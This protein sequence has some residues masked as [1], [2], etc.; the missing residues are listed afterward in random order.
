MYISSY[1]IFLL[2]VIFF[3]MIRR[4]PRST[5]TDTLFPYTTLFRSH[6]RA[7]YS[8]PRP[9]DRRRVGPAHHGDRGR[10][11]RHRAGLARRS[12]WPADVLPA[13]RGVR[14]LHPLLFLLGVENRCFGPSPG[15]GRPAGNCVIGR[16]PCREKMGQTWR[17]TG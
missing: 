4:P 2:V 16:A 1:I 15:S 17:I 10:R 5:R 14:A 13:H 9:A 11:A 6:L 3:L 7:R 8:R 12:L